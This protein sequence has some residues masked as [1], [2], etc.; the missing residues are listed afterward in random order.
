[1]AS[2]T[3]MVPEPRLATTTLP[4]ALCAPAPGEAKP[5]NRRLN[6]IVTRKITNA[7]EELDFFIDISPSLLGIRTTLRRN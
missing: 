4:R 5:L 3:E 6:T 1:L 2:M 7:P